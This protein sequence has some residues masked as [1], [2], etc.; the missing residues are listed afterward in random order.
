M[1]N[2]WKKNDIHLLQIHLKISITSIYQQ[3]ENLKIIYDI[4]LNR[5]IYRN[6]KGSWKLHGINCYI[7]FIFSIE[8][9]RD[10]SR[11]ANLQHVGSSV[12]RLFE[13]ELKQKCGWADACSVDEF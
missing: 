4:K 13:W 11:S 12:L 7:N 2:N 1:D 9:V 5:C 6:H 3:I 10:A 8:A